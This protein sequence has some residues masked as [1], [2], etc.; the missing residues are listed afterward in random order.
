[1]GLFRKNGEDSLLAGE[2]LG[3][4]KAPMKVTE[5]WGGDRRGWPEAGAGEQSKQA[6]SSM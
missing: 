2:D 4:N 5:A 6:L 1:M 3:R